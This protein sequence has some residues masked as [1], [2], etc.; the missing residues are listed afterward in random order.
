MISASD[1]ET[2]FPE[3]NPGIKPLGPRVLVQLRLT[4]SKTKSGIEIVT[5]TKDFND[6]IAQFAKVIRLGPLAFRDRSTGKEWPEGMWAV[7]GDI[8]R[9]P[10]YGGDRFAKE[11]PEGNVIFVIFDDTLVN[12]VI[13][14]ETFTSLDELV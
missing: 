2:A 6:S 12:A 3:V 1:L 14:H 7:P 5:S 4:R 9:V 11:T 8:V 10:K 13:D